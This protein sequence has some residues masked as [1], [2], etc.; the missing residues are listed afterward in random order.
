MVNSRYIRNLSAHSCHI[1]L[2]LLRGSTKSRTICQI[3]F[4]SAQSVRYCTRA[5]E[6]ISQVKSILEQELNHEQDWTKDKEKC[7]CDNRFGLLVEIIEP[8]LTLTNQNIYFNL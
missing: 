2:E 8:L 3:K 7:V 5:I 4:N 1:V 6:F